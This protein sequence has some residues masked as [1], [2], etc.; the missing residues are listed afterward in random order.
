MWPPLVHAEARREH[1]KRDERHGLKTVSESSQKQ[2]DKVNSVYHE[3]QIN[4]Q[5]R[6]EHPMKSHIC[7]INRGVRGV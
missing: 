4:P 3:L 1:Q 7:R 6:N 5:L 2:D